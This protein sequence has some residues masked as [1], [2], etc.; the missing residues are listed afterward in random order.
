MRE[1]SSILNKARFIRFRS[2]QRNNAKKNK[3]DHTHT[4]FM[5]DRR[6]ILKSSSII[7][8]FDWRK[9]NKINWLWTL[10]LRLYWTTPTLFLTHWF[11]QTRQNLK[12]TGCARVFFSLYSLT[13][14]ITRADFQ[15]INF[16]ERS[17]VINIYHN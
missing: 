8:Y 4:Q 12:R 5:N 11:S 1:I 13:S 7:I 2:K 16:W 9:I 6:I 14:F 10:T 15:T 3:K 17:T